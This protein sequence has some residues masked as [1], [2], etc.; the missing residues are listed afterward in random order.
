MGETAMAP[1]IGRSMLTRAGRDASGYRAGSPFG[2]SLDRT[3]HLALS[4]SLWCL[5]MAFGSIG[6]LGHVAAHL[7]A[8]SR[9]RSGSGGPKGP[10]PAIANG[11]IGQM[12]VLVGYN[13]KKHSNEALHWAAR[14]R[15]IAPLHWLSS[16]RPTIQG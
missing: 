11:T 1:A 4:L 3:S 14:S 9:Q 13:G 8:D 16:S 15:S 5:E 6:N 7:F 2:T 12:P 10:K